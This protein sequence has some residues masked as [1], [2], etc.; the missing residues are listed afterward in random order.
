MY[1][2]NKTIGNY[3]SAAIYDLLSDEQKLPLPNEIFCQIIKNIYFYEDKLTL[4]L[5]CRQIHKI[6]LY[7]ERYSHRNEIQLFINAFQ[8]YVDQ[9]N[10]DYQ[11][12]KLKEFKNNGNQNLSLIETAASDIKL[13][14]VKSFYNYLHPKKSYINIFH[15]LND[16]LYKLRLQTK[17]YIAAF[18]FTKEPNL[19]KEKI[20]EVL[21]KLDYY[22]SL[23]EIFNDSID[24]IYLDRLIL[25]TRPFNLLVRYYIV[26]PIIIILAAHGSRESIE[27]IEEL[28][29]SFESIPGGKLLILKKAAKS[30]MTDED[31]ESIKKALILIK[32]NNIRFEFRDYFWLRNVRK[33]LLHLGDKKSLEITV[34][35]AL[36]FNCSIQKFRWFKPIIKAFVKLKDKENL[37]KIV[38]ILNK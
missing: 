10:L 33:N 24:K 35:L 29:S 16:V 8:L 25:Q 1:A 31:S 34:N 15:Y 36:S 17:Y 32:N 3:P 7:E 19:H 11:I 2:L 28:S 9:E 4:S 20:I 13:N 22:K 26:K 23:K 14:I 30:L 37:E 27:K 21:A 5:T 18:F 12:A 6:V 38:Y